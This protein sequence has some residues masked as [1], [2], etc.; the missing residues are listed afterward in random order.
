MFVIAKQQDNIDLTENLVVFSKKT[1]YITYKPKTLNEKM[2]LTL[3]EIL[4]D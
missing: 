1:Y 2:Q 4:K 3:V